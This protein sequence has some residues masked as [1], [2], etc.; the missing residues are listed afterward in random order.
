M[1]QYVYQNE[2]KNKIGSYTSRNCGSGYTKAVYFN[3][4]IDLKN[5]SG[6]IRAS[7][8]RFYLYTNTKYNV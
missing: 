5:D 8:D 6:E 2:I 4:N 7:T 3:Y 1:I